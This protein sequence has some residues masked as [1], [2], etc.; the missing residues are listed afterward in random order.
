MII[1][2]FSFWL[3][4]AESRAARFRLVSR[5]LRTKSLNGFDHSGECRSFAENSYY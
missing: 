2:N 3:I 5:M 1:D 4:P